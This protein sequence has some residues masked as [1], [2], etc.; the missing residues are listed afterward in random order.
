MKRK[1]TGFH[2]PKNTQKNHL[3]SLAYKSKN[4][5]LARVQALPPCYT[6]SRKTIRDPM[7]DTTAAAET[8]TE[9]A[10]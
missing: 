4:H 9:D 7:T 2:R 6:P 8:T 5:I 1:L 3:T 10:S